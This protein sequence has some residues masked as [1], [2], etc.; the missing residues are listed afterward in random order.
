MR[1]E[2]EIRV[3][4]K[5]TFREVINDSIDIERRLAANSALPRNKNVEYSKS[6]E[7]TNNKNNKVTRFNVAREDKFVCLIILI[8]QILILILIL[9]KQHNFLYPDQQRY[10]NF[11]GQRSSETTTIPTI[12][13]Q[14]TIFQEIKIIILII[15]TII[16]YKIEITI[17]ETIIVIFYNKDTTIIIIFLE[18]CTITTT[19]LIIIIII[20][21]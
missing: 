19:M 9:N 16:F 18:I 15:T 7:P 8:K 3:E 20:D 21:N 2:L 11:N 12:I 17:I 4:E 13:F 14:I 5:D 1:P 10:N 6:D